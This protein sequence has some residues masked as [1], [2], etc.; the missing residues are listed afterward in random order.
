MET[1]LIRTFL[2]VARTRNFTTAAGELH[3]SQSTVT[4][5]IQTLERTLDVRLFDRVPRGAHLTDAG[6]R[7]LPAADAVQD[8]EQRLRAA[9]RADAVPGGVVA[10]AAGDTLCSLHLPEVIASL[11]GSHPGIGVH[12][13]PAGT[14][15]ALDALLSGRADLALLLEDTVEHPDAHTEVLAREPLQF[16]GP[17][18]HPLT[19][20]DTPATWRELAAEDVYLHEEGC[21]Y[22]DR[23]AA[24]LR[25]TA[26]GDRLLTRLGSSEAVRNCVAAGL[27]ISVLP[28]SAVH[29]ALAAGTLR[30][31]NGPAVD[32]VPVR[33]ARH[34]TRFA[35]PA[36]RVV[37]Q[38]LT[39][40]FTAG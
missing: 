13:R 23:I 1:Q 3:L 9:A 28:R 37:A 5:Q 31:V 29:H 26:A 40:H 19:T 35:S 6:R 14:R 22:S 2:V 30:P 10:V 25:A 24:H 8:A 7:L 18:G 38:A 20:R 17:P 34:R 27:G 36:V 33:L 15:A 11:R 32:D 12:L 39:D 21:S 4:A 16:V